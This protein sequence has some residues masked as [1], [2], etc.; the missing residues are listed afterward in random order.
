MMAQKHLHNRSSWALQNPLRFLAQQ[1]GR[2]S[3]SPKGS[4]RRTIRHDS[5]TLPTIAHCSTGCAGFP[6]GCG[7]VVPWAGPSLIRDAIRLGRLTAL[8]K[9]NGGVRRIVAGDIVGRLVAPTISQQVVEAVQTA[10][11]P[12]QYALS[13]RSGCECVA[14]ALQGLTEIDP[15][16]TVTSIDGI[17]AYDLISRQAMLEGVREMPGG[18]HSPFRLNVLWRSLQLPL[19]RR[20][21]AGPHHRSGRR[22]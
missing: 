7:E 10:T 16:A 22:K 5:G 8:K 9:P 12:F 20:I 4:G 13:T 2:S 21:G 19:G 6:P 11:T 18:I 15:R 1:L 3:V 14:H 17:S